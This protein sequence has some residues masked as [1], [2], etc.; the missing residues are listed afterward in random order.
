MNP[1]PAIGCANVVD[2]G[3]GFCGRHMRCLNKDLRRE[4]FYS[5][6]HQEWDEYARVMSRGREILA[7][8]EGVNDGRANA[9]AY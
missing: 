4:I 5:F 3:F 9:S 6:N 8:Q 7:I 1:C 2:Q